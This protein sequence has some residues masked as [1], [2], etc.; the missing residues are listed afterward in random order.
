MLS[1]YTSY[2]YYVMVS[3]GAGSINSDVTTA[4]TAES[5]PLGMDPPITQT[6]INQLNTIY[7]S[8]TLPASPN[9]KTV[10]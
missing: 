6:Q 10:L 3:N 1:P 9:G 5:L 2:H 4:V 8:W 7:L